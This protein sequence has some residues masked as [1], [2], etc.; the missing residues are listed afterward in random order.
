MRFAHTASAY[1]IATGC[2]LALTAGV[3]AGPSCNTQWKGQALKGNWQYQ[4]GSN[5]CTPLTEVEVTVVVSEDIVVAGATKGYSGFSMQLNANGPSSG[6]TP[7]QLYWQQF[8]IEVD[9]GNVSGF[10]QQWSSGKQK[11]PINPNSISLGAPSTTKKRFVTISAGT[12]FKW[13]L[14]TDSKGNVESV[15]YRATDDLGTKYTPVTE[16]IPEGDR[17]PIYSITMDIVGE[18]NASLTTF[19]SG[20]GT[21]TYT[22]KSF[23]ASYDFPSCANNSGTAESSNMSYGPL[24]ATSGNFTQEF[25]ICR[26]P[27]PL[28]CQGPFELSAKSIPLHWSLKGAAAESPGPGKCAWADRGPRPAEITKGN[29][30]HPA[31][32]F[33]PFGGFV[34]AA[35]EAKAGEYQEF[36]VYRDETQG[37]CMHLYAGSDGQAAKRVSPPFSSSI[38]CPW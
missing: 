3:R 22:A 13:K 25:F 12:T 32:V 38:D 14:H 33:C 36:C 5:S 10:T 18:S 26:S 19:E 4:L 28:F 24:N 11:G 15:T 9:P 27:P 7:S 30:S 1:L 21:I 8:V 35:F 37:N 16:D 20:A 17:A 29:P 2:V 23:S 6:L 31:N 34:A